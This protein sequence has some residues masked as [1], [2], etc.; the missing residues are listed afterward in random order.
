MSNIICI[1]V[2]SMRILFINRWV[3]YNEGGNE[4]HIKELAVFLSRR[5]HKVDV[6][7]TGY[8]AL[9][10]IKD[11]ITDIIE[12][13]S[14]ERYFAY[15][16]EAFFYSAKYIVDSLLTLKM[17]VKDR[18]KKYDI[19]SV[20]FS[21]EAVLAR[22]IKFIFGIPYVMVLAGD[23]PLELIEG[24]RADGT[25]HISEFMNA[26]CK[27]Y[28]YSAEII[29]KGIDLERFRPDIDVKDLKKEHKIKDGDKVLLAVCRLDPRKSLT[30]LIDAMNV[31]VN[32]KGASEYKLLIVGDGV[33]NIKLGKMVE[34]YN[35]E[36][37]V[38][39]VGSVPNNSL[40]LPKYYVLA[41][42]FVLPTLYEGFGWVYME[43]MASGTPI[44]TTKV[45]SNPEIVGGIGR[46][47]E[48][49]NPDLLAKNIMELINNDREMEKMVKKGFEKTKFYLWE[50][51]A[52]KYEEFYQ[53]VSE[54]KCRN[55]LCKLKVLIYLIRDSIFI[56]YFLVRTTFTSLVTS[57]GSGEWASGQVGSD[58]VLNPS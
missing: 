16:K 36:D 31:V 27:K 55:L 20:H 28:G 32:K 34:I 39:F 45:G 4:T 3:G 9:E 23:T 43:A 53:K 25:V 19:I 41:D 56:F 58:K 29:P 54:K 7:T 40:L 6:M 48:P 11:K 10:P 22:F 35:L 1:I 15:N 2:G 14:K 33:E 57:R 44:L 8:K 17:L 30:T 47:I 49:K 51:L 38:T 5:G 46:L 50:N 37:N 13:P 21:L 42:L 26:Q 24:K 18:K 12:V 52:P